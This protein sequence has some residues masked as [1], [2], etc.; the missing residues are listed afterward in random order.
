MAALDMFESEDLL[1]KTD[2]NPVRG[3]G[4]IAEHADMITQKIYGW[5][6]GDDERI[7]GAKVSEWMKE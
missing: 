5:D 6:E 1:F 7:N 3:T 2:A 4:N